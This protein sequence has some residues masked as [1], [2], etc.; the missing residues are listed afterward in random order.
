MQKSI[1]TY[2]FFILPFCI[3]AQEGTRFYLTPSLG[4]QWGFSQFEDKETTPDYVKSANLVS[5][6]RY[7]IGLM[8]DFKEKWGLEVGYGGADLGLGLKYASKTDS[9]ESEVSG[10]KIRYTTIHR[11]YLQVFSPGKLVFIRKRRGAYLRRYAKEKKEY[12]FLSVFNLGFLGGISYE[13]VSHF[14]NTNVSENASEVNT[15]DKIELFETSLQKSEQNGL[16]IY[17]GIYTQFLNKGEKRLQLGIVYQ[18]GLQKRIIS[19]WSTS[20]NGVAQPD[21][22]TFTRNSYLS[23]Y[24]CYPI[25]LFTLGLKK[26]KKLKE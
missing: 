3:Y 8:V 21:F 2:L 7:G 18:Q 24:A 23:F 13:S 25:K 17:F 4:V 12:D 19:N 1:F 10:R 22:Q 26:S 6:A 9:V 16:G 20:I 15:F 11:A 5:G 14:S